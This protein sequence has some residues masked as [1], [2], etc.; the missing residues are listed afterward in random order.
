MSRL[1]NR[2]N[3]PSYPTPRRLRPTRKTFCCVTL[4]QWSHLSEPVF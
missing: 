1:L 2:K 4:D 3:I